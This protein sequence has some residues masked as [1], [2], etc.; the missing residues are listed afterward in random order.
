MNDY[1]L[2]EKD[3][4][5]RIFAIIIIASVIPALSG[6]EKKSQPAANSEMPEITEENLNSELDRLE[7]E[8]ESEMTETE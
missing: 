8:I 7:Q 5:R 1:Q 2:M 6:C 4:F 3:M